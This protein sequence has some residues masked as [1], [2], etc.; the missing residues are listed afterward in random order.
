MHPE[1]LA[2]HEDD[3]LVTVAVR[4]ARARLRHACVVNGEG[5]V[6]GILS[7][8]DLRRAFGDPRRA[9]VLE[10]ESALAAMWRV[11]DVMTEKPHSVHED[12]SVETA[13]RALATNRLGA[14]PVVGDDWRLHG[15]VSYIDVLEYFARA[16]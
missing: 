8:R 5:R 1:P 12:D 14:L 7:D 4:M 10:R 11:R 16:Q 6:I 15:I 9:S 13:A 3:S 2:V